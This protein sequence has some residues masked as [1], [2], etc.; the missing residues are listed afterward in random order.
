MAD[1]ATIFSRLA[2]FL[3]WWGYGWSLYAWTEHG[4][5]WRVLGFIPAALAFGLFLVLEII[6]L[7]IR[8]RM[9]FGF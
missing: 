2:C 4:P 1:A 8:G 6:F 5:K 9:V 7:I 3:A